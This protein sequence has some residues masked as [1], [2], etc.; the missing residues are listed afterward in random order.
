MGR[1]CAG[2]EG[3]WCEEVESCTDATV[4]NTRH[5]S[6][7]IASLR[8]NNEQV[9]CSVVVGR[10]AKQSYA[11]QEENGQYHEEGEERQVCGRGLSILFVRRRRSLFCV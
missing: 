11:A 8:F 7:A 10:S 3:R 6:N 9:G 2:W 5:K 1:S 4:R